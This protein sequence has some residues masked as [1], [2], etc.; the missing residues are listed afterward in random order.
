LLL[1]IDRFIFLETVTG[2][3]LEL[4]FFGIIE[5][6]FYTSNNLRVVSGCAVLRSDLIMYKES[7]N[8]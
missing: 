7:S 2:K 8:E 1:G 5:V 6:A 4:S 3:Q